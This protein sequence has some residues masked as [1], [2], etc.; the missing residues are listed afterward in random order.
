[1]VPADAIGQVHHHNQ[2]SFNIPSG[3]SI[4]TAL[5]LSWER[6]CKAFNNLSIQIKRFGLYGISGIQA[7]L[8]ELGRGIHF[9]AQKA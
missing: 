1:M 2:Y 4:I 7:R 5:F 6:G 8:V 9:R 3:I